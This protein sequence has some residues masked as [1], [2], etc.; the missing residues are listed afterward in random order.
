MKMWIRIFSLVVVLLVLVWLQLLT[1]GQ[2][3][4]LLF[5]ALI[6]VLV[7]GVRRVNGK[8]VVV[9]K[10]QAIRS[11]AAIGYALIGAFIGMLLGIPLMLVGTGWLA[12]HLPLDSILQQLW[13]LL[14]V[15]PVFGGA[16]MGYHIAKKY[17]NSLTLPDEYNETKSAASDNATAKAAGA[18]E[19]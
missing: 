19:N 14:F 12:N 7:G 1:L 5:A 15:G 18:V 3:G 16:W 13:I 2:A 11:L 9:D 4:M 8:N 6:P 17:P 10:V